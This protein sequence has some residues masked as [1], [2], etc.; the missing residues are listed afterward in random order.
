MTRFEETLPSFRAERGMFGSRTIA[1]HL[2][3]G[4]IGG[5]AL[6]WTAVNWPH[7]PWLALM[8]IGVAMAAMRGCPMCWAAGLIETIAS[9][10]KQS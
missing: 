7:H 10:M 1:A 8:S 6:A 2:M 9:R 5:G 3:R 4:A